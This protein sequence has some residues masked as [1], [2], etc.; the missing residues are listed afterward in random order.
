MF[1]A[2]RAFFAAAPHLP[3]LPADE[4]RRL[5]PRYRWRVMEATYLGY[6]TF[7]LVR[8]NI[9][10]V[11]KDME[12]AIGYND[13]QIGS[14]LAI[15]AI[16]YGL[17]KFLMGAVSDRSNPRVF[18]A[19][20]LLLTALCNFAFGGVKGFGI[21]L[22]LWGLNGFFQGMGW[23][24]CGRSM[25]HW[26]SQKERGLTFSIWN[27]AHNVGGGV[28]GYLAGWAALRLGGWQYAFFVPGL[29][30]LVGSLYLFWRLCDTPQSV[31]LPPIEEYAAGR[32]GGFPVQPVVATEAEPQEAAPVASC[33]SASDD[34]ERE[35]GFGE[36]FV[37]YV[38]TNKYVW[39]LAIANFFAYVSRYSMLDWGPKYLREVKDAT[40]VKG[41]LAV[42]VL[43][44]AGIASTIALGWVSDRVGGRRGMVATLSMAPILAAFTAILFIPAGYLWMDMVMLGLIG[45]FIYPVINLIVIQALD[46]TSKK[47]I[48]T[49]AGFIGLLGYL[50]RTCQ[51]QGFGWMLDYFKPR[52]GTEAAWEI[53]I[54]SI[55]GCTAMAVLLLAFTWKLRPRA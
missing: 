13:G 26:F 30:A 31:G 2:I 43:E 41:G 20:G 42:M 54:Y 15:T 7:Y 3:R 38:L 25:G 45:F 14:I 18:M 24:P 12:A 19:F 51:A 8:N 29:L 5:Y 21:H 40:L 37:D 47:A 10:V 1:S 16:S 4:V 11:S 46:L 33:A 44:F 36:L 27:T 55:L 52:Y 32:G 6:A 34:A 49:A 9:S 35:L 50:G 53:V 28:A 22:T 17:G 39:L 23:P 48:G